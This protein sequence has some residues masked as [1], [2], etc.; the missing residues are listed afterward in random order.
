ML[1]S[2][3]DEIMQYVESDLTFS[4]ELLVLFLFRFLLVVIGGLV[5]RKFGKLVSH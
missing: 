5:Y 4:W 1:R 2:Y 3:C